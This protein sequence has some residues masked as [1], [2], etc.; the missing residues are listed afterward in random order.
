MKEVACSAQQQ[1]NIVA[2]AGHSGKEGN[3]MERRGG[4]K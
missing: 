3:E 2:R 4:W 1:V